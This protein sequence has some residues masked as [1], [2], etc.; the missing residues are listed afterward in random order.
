MT[1][2]SNETT[3][4]LRNVWQSEK[5]AI[6]AWVLSPDP[7]LA[8]ATA[9]AGYDWVCIDAQ[10]G[11]FGLHDLPALIQA[12]ALAGAAPIVRVPANE[13]WLI[14]RALDAGAF[15]VMVP[16][17]NSAQ[18]AAKAVAACR[19]APTGG[20]SV[21]AFRPAPGIATTLRQADR[22]VICM[23][24]IESKAAVENIEEICAVPGLDAVYIGPGDLYLSLGHKS[25]SETDPNI[26][27]KIRDTALR[28]GVMPGMHGE[29]GE[30]ARWA[31][32]NGF[33]HTTTGVDIDF[34]HREAR[35][36]LAIAKGVEESK[37]GAHSWLN[38]VPRAAVE[39]GSPDLIR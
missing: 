8:E 31:V 15:G 34:L 3:N 12:V 37:L 39:T 22:E 18:E 32:N 38:G 10:H 29:T 1:A 21:G 9:L 19:Y 30:E 23:V 25:K 5:T 4:Q 33:K 14:G 16:L 11:W 13:T 2:S 35:K 7:I 36:A 24:Q 27:F 6:G 26:L 28:N 17:V 20:R